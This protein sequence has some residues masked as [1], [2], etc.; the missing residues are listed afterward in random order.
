MTDL[1]GPRWPDEDRFLHDLAQALGAA[2]LAA[3]TLELTF[4]REGQGRGPRVAISSVLTQLDRARDML[5]A[6]AAQLA[7][8]ASGP[9]A[10]LR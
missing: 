4:E 5:R 2:S 8:E 1:R 9:G 3:E 6:R 10:L 7:D